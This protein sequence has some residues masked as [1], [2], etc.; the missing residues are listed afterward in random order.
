MW[1]PLQSSNTNLTFPQ[2]SALYQRKIAAPIQELHVHVTQIHM[3]RNEMCTH[4]HIHVCL[5]VKV[6]E[7]KIIFLA[8]IITLFTKY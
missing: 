5:K 2:K 4:V 3:S 7:E 6:K 1:C 8:K